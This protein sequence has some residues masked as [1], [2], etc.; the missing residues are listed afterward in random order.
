[1]TNYLNYN[2]ILF[3]STENI[4]AATNR[5]F[6]YGDGLFESIRIVNGKIFNVEEHFKRLTKGASILKI[7]LPGNMTINLFSEQI[8]NLAKKN[9]HLPSARVRFTLFRDDGGLYQP[10]S[11]NGKYLIESSNINNDCFELN[12]KGLMIGIYEETKKLPGPLSSIKSCN[13]LP[14]I[15]AKIFAT[16]NGYDDCLILNNQNRIAEATSSNVFIIKGNTIV[17][18]AIKEGC[19]IGTMRNLIISIAKNEGL[20]II[21]SEININDLDDADEVFLT[22]AVSGVKWVHTC[23]QKMYRNK[24][25]RLFISKLNDLI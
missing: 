22:N 8:L 12:E 17:T 14:Y 24:H 21:E 3:P 25:A 1:M 9:S 5:A 19:V 20:E 16:D 2:N 23:K 11:N 7:T 6:S 18:P 4:F 15:M 10:V 13:S